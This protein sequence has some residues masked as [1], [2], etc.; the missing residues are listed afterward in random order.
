[1]DDGLTRKHLL[2]LSDGRDIET[3]TMGYPGRLTACVSTQAGCAMGCVFCATGQMGFFRHLRA[4]E[5]VAQVLH[6]RRH[7]T[8]TGGH[9]RNV[10]MMGMGEP[11]HN[12]DNVMQA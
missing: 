7:M 8:P 4:G 5:I 1:S 11:L 12:Y 2:R 9:L 6:A 3:V 10:V